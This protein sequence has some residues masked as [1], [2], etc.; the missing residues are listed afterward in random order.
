MAPSDDAPGPAAIDVDERVAALYGGPLGAFVAERGAL[1]RTLRGAGR[2][3][4][5]AAVKALRK[6]KALAWA[7]NAGGRADPEAVADLVS[8]VEAVSGAQETGGDV[9]DAIARLRT[10][11]S[12]LV[13]AAD[14]AARGHDHPVDRTAVAAALRAVV[15]DPEALAALA[16]GRLVD[17]AAPGGGGSGATASPRTPSSRRA[18]PPTGRHPARAGDAGDRPE[19]VGR[20]ARPDRA[21]ISAARRTLRQ[22]EKAVAVAGRAADKAA[23]RAVDAEAHA[24]EADAAARRAE[25]AA[26]EARRRAA[27]AVR[28]AGEQRDRAAAAET[29]RARAEADMAAA[30][31]ALDELTG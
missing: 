20:V 31:T 26:E 19:S 21:A 1:A 22:A 9:R 7:L 28:R 30:Q 29:A 5:A 12:A 10:A 6:P 2:G 25:A 3:D 15:G 17:T 11:E 23:A 4:E 18:T 27:D 24:A 8:A 13:D 16:A 14:Q